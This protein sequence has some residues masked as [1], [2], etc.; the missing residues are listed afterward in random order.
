MLSEITPIVLT[1]N[2]APNIGRTLGKLT[3]AREI[4]VVDSGSTDETVEIVRQFPQAK[5]L[6]RS[7]DSHTD[8]WNFGL[9]NVQTEWV[10]S[11][12]ADY[13]LPREFT[14]E[15]ASLRP[16]D[17]MVAYFARFRYCIFG[18]PLRATLYPPRAVL[19]RKSFCRYEP[20][21]HT[22]TL[23][24][25]GRTAR[26][27]AEIN[28]DDQK[29][30]SHWLRAQDRYAQLESK[31]LLQKPAGQLNRSDQIRRKI[32]LAPVLVLFYALL[33]KGLILDGWAGCYYVFQ[34]TL[35][36]LILSL[37]L[38]EARLKQPET[39]DSTSKTACDGG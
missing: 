32:V 21:G 7:F 28:H 34:R 1:F 6:V 2:E 8:Q 33:G 24:T 4:V 23:R 15:L 9:D 26:L 39:S 5:V 11:L 35:A 31:H 19:F 3:W 20:D 37:R 36:E 30:F 10:L 12:D 17:N 14:A 25:N 13:I 18:R 16:P 22:Q 27:S 29:P 38:I